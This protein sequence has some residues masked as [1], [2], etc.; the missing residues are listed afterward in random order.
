MG[1][2]SEA[3][4][5]HVRN[6]RLN[7]DRTHGARRRGD[8]HSRRRHE[9][10]TRDEAIAQAHASSIMA[11]RE[12]QM[13]IRSAESTYRE[14]ERIGIEFDQRLE[15]VKQELRAAGCLHESNPRT[16]VS[17]AAPARAR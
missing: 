4:A 17:T 13:S 10:W 8:L 16:T 3:T 9:A 12:L 6:E 14:I 11:E 1:P 15:R 5:S 7:V 2:S